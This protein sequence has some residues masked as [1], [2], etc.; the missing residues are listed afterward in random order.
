MENGAAYSLQ[1]LLASLFTQVTRRTECTWSRAIPWSWSEAFFLPTYKLMA[2]IIFHLLW[3]IQIS[4]SF[5]V[6]HLG[7]FSP[8]MLAYHKYWLSMHRKLSARRTTSLFYIHR[9]NIKEEEHFQILHPSTWCSH[10]VD[11]GCWWA[12]R[13]WLLSPCI[14]PF[15]VPYMGKGKSK[16]AD[17]CV[18]D[19]MWLPIFL[20]I[21]A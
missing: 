3:T 9:G 6:R 11:I 1:E 15:Y 16:K 19:Y 21:F 20:I 18:H 10:L 17:R 12:Y 13:Q 7:A 2:A 4:L 14:S 5:I 8:P